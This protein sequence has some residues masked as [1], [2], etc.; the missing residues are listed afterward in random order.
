VTGG[1]EQIRSTTED[2]NSTAAPEET[3]LPVEPDHDGRGDEP[4]DGEAPSG[5]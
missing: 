2:W 1:G 5:G 4:D 3:P